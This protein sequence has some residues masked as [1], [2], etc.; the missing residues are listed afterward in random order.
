MAN[1]VIHIECTASRPISEVSLVYTGLL[2]CTAEKK[3]VPFSM[4]TPNVALMRECVP[5][6]SRM[7]Q[8]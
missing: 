2:S 7:G 5:K 1:K 6:H 4:A 8:Q 3:Q